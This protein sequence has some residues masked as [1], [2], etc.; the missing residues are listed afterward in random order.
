M[1]SDLLWGL[2]RS[3]P[4]ERYYW[5]V[6]FGRLK[7]DGESFEI[8]AWPAVRRKPP[9]RYGSISGPSF[10]SATQRTL[11][12]PYK[13]PTASPPLGTTAP[14]TLPR[15]R[16]HLAKTSPLQRGYQD[17]VII[18]SRGQSSVVWHLQLKKCTKMKSTEFPSP[19]RLCKV[20]DFSQINHF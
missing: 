14:A 4:S 17:R 13:G 15:D 19:P 5:Q 3:A 11:S 2:A 16:C 6:P 8:I 1:H 7:K 10:Q 20:S 9:G 18:V 12:L